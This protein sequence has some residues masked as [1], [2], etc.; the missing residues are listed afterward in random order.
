MSAGH[1]HGHDEVTPDTLGAIL[2]A[3]RT[4]IRTPESDWISL[5]QSIACG[6]QR[7]LHTLYEQTHR[8]VFTLA[9]RIV[10]DHETAEEVTIDVYH[11][12][13]RRAGE[14]DPAGVP[15]VGWIMNLARWRSLDQLKSRQRKK[16]SAGE[17]GDAGPSAA[18]D[19]AE[20]CEIREEYRRL[21]AALAA[22]T[23][24]E[25]Q[26]IE[27]AFFSEL[28]Y[29]DTAVKLNEPMGTVKTRIRSG[30]QKLRQAMKASLSE[31]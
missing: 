29:L 30:L 2:Y 17:T 3:D 23:P 12:L 1:G 4:K 26:A 14:Y 22:L 25:R 7:A 24:G 27:T 8:L 6:D 21:R 19:P 15:V 20:E 10:G 28:S 16:R 18:A 31:R 13:W 9:F 5:V 11:D